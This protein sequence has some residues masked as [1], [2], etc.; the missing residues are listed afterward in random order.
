MAD[1]N[2]K[3]QTFAAKA[4]A[5]VP[6]P[7]APA[8][9][10]TPPAGAGAG[11]AGSTAGNGSAGAGAS[12]GAGSTVSLENALSSSIGARIRVSLAA[13][14]PMTIEGS[15]FAVC[16]LTNIVAI[17]TAPAPAAPA[18]NDGANANVTAGQ[19]LAQPTNIHFVPVSRIQSFDLLSLAPPAVDSQQQQQQQQSTPPT[20]TT[21]TST[22]TSTTQHAP[23]TT[24][25]PAIYPLDTRALHARAAAA[26]AEAQEQ[27]RRRG[28]GVTKEA[29]DIF[30]A[31]S[32]TMPA[33]WEGTSIIVADQVLITAPYRAETC[34]P[35]G[36]NADMN[37]AAIIRVRKVL[38]MERKKMELRNASATLGQK[39]NFKG[40]SNNNTTTTTTTNTSTPG[41]VNG[42]NQNASGPGTP[43]PAATPIPSNPAA[44]PGTGA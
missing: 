31:F 20:T 15:V 16:H 40:S 23:F 4:A 6:G 10:P 37:S 22:T 14:T 39:N 44:I 42:A 9:T 36:P 3:R 34:N 8:A 18:D 12:A 30:D 25:I 21:T 27:E 41:R 11:A 24:A 17:D 26:V 38:E 2:S 28:K 1:D 13:P 29:Q 33:R 35:Y 19:A 43:V 32:R 5:G 7:A